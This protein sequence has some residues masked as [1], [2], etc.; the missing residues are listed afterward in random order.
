[1]ETRTGVGAE[2]NSG[3]GQNGK[4]QISVADRHRNTAQKSGRIQNLGPW[5]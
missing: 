2:K 3:A 5:G 1:M 4:L